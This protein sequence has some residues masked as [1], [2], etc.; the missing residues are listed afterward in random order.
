MAG[1]IMGVLTVVGHSADAVVNALGCIILFCT[2]RKVRRQ[3][4]L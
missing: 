4:S 1:S 2:R 3:G